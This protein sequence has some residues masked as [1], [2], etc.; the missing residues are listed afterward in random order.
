MCDFL[1][2]LFVEKI[3]LKNKYPSLVITQNLNIHLPN[4]FY[5]IRWRRLLR[6]KIE[7]HQRKEVNSSEYNF[8]P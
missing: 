7:I 1:N 8:Y 2:Y 3:I 6:L 5:Y 4:L